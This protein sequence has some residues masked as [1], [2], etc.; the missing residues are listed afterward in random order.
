M[1]GL[2][3]VREELRRPSLLDVDPTTLQGGE[4]ERFGVGALPSSLEEALDE[5]ES[6]ELVRSWFP[7]LLYDAYVSLKRG[8]LAAVAELDLAE[9]CRLYGNAY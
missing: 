7:P 4:A 8:E 2:A 9:R 1:A 6:D 3:G 5:L